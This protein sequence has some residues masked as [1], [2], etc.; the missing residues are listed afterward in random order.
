MLPST[1]VEQRHGSRN[2]LRAH[3]LIHKLEG[4][5]EKEGRK[6]ERQMQRYRDRDT[7]S[8]AETQRQRDS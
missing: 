4:V 8:D 1:V 3:I 7:E 2:S 6:R 5:R